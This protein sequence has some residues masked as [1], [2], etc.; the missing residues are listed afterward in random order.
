MNYRWDILHIKLT[1]LLIK[2]DLERAAKQLRDGKYNTKR[3]SL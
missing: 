1:E 2:R 3:H